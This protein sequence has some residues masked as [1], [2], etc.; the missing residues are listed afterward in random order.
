M[1]MYK[2]LRMRMLIDDVFDISHQRILNQ[3]R[4]VVRDI[5]IC[6]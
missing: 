2:D 5:I 4:G 6:E 1:P 3:G